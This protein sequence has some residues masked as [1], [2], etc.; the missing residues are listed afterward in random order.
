[1][2]IAVPSSEKYRKIWNEL[3][4]SN[5]LTLFHQERFFYTHGLNFRQSVWFAKVSFTPEDLHASPCSFPEVLIKVRNSD[6]KPT[7]HQAERSQPNTSESWRR[8]FRS[9][10]STHFTL[11]S[12]L[13]PSL[14]CFPQVRDLFLWS[15]ACSTR[16]W[17]HVATSVPWGR[18]YCQTLAGAHPASYPPYNPKTMLIW[19][20]FINYVTL[21][22]IIYPPLSFH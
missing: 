15:P 17:A 11:L 10:P 19:R 3:L 2:Y 1:M 8:S 14:Q 21:S 16:P 20:K 7:S 12:H 5:F 22:L 6:E 13:S 18:P 4:M 9:F